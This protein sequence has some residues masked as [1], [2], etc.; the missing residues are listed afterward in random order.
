M[1]AGGITAHGLTTYSPLWLMIIRRRIISAGIIVCDVITS[2]IIACDTTYGIA[3]CRSA[4][5]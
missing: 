2:G 5:L 4:K 1:T 3:T